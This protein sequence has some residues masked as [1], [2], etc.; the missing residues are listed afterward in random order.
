MLASADMKTSQEGDEHPAKPGSFLPAERQSS[1][2]TQGS[3]LLSSHS[4]PAELFSFPLQSASRLITGAP[5]SPGWEPI[6]PEFIDSGRRPPVAPSLM[7]QELINWTSA[8]LMKAMKQDP[9]S[10]SEKSRCSDP[11]NMIKIH[12]FHQD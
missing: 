1:R 10:L 2:Q 12:R 7:H 5:G 6:Y 9:A 11:Q 3:F 4:L 8:E